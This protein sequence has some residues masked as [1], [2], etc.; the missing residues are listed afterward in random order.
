MKQYS[1]YLQKITHSSLIRF[2][3]RHKRVLSIIVLII[4]FVLLGFYISANPAVLKSVIGIGIPK[5]ILLL[6]LYLGVLVTN[7]GVMYAT[8]KLR[9]KHLHAKDGILLIIYSSFI[10]FFGPLQSGPA[11]RAIY[12]KAKLGLRI[13]DYT[14]AMLFYYFAFAFINVSLIFINRWAWLSFVGIAVGI[15]LTIFAS[16]KLNFGP[17]RKYVLYIFL[18]TLLQIIM[19]VVIYSVELWNV[20]PGARYS[21][22]QTISYTGSA[23]LSLFVSL[24][25]GGIGIRE[26]FLVFSQSLHQIPLNSI[27]AAGILDRAM[28]IVFIVIL[29]AVSSSLHL[30]QSLVGKHRL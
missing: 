26:A 22:L 14:Y 27:V 6:S 12:L 15:I 28:Y 13:R 23:N 20:N 16:N 19:M 1:L 4:S 9:D 18:L 17:L 3:S 29:F 24:T 2:F 30:K 7:F 5:S 25:P 8:V 10:N 21:I 11:V